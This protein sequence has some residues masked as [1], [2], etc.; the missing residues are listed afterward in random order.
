MTWL[1]LGA[2][3]LA[4]SFL[5]VLFQPSEQFGNDS[6]TMVIL[7]SWI[8]RTAFWLGLMFVAGHIL[9]RVFARDRNR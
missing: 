9:D 1:R 2:A 8:A 3:L 6:R 5:A 4:I 7:D